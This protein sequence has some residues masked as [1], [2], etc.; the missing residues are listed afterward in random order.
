MKKTILA[1]GMVLLMAG[2][3]TGCNGSE[4]ITANKDIPENPQNGQTEEPK[5]PGQEQPDKDDFIVYMLPRA[6]QI[7]LT[8]EQK[9]L[10]K[11]N[12]DFSM[13]LF[14]TINEMDEKKRSNFL[15]PI[16]V[17]YMLGMLNDGAAGETSKEILSMLGFGE[18]DTQSVNELCK[19]L[20]YGAPNV[21]PNVSVEISSYIAA[22]SHRGVTLES[23]FQKDME[24]YYKAEA[25]SLDFS[26]PDALK[27]INGWCSEKTDGKIDKMLE[28]LDATSLLVL[29]NAVNFKATWVS[30]FDEA[31]TLDETFTMDDGT[32]KQLPMMH[33][34]AFV[35]FGSNDVYSTILLPYG[36]ANAEWYMYILHPQENKTVEDVL[37]AMSNEDM[38]KFFWNTSVFQVDIKIPRFKTT[39]ENDLIQPIKKLGAP[40]IFNPNKADFPKMC[41][42]YKNLYVSKL[43]QK[44]AVDVNEN[45]TEAVAVT[46]AGINATSVGIIDRDKAYFYCDSP[47]VYVIQEQSSGAVFFIGTFRGE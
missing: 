9:A 24:T 11:K 46:A 16:S 41:S 12:N 27:T 18:S 29:L 47:F 45:G 26:S 15:S 21:D 32:T 13:N 39:S 31:N 1:F 22:N 7:E 44:A 40:S 3:L 35:R 6:K 34:E 19:A 33:Q 17:T 36:G 42:N 2:M 25:A 4:D 38:T 30:K 8:Q 23:L 20:I 14:K 43:L 10:V 37:E 5:D 28:E